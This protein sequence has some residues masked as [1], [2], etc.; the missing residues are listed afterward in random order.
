[1]NDFSNRMNH[2]SGRPGSVEK[3][4]SVTNVGP[5]SRF[6]SWPPT[7]FVSRFMRF[8]FLPRQWKRG[9]DASPGVVR[10]RSIPSHRLTRPNVQG[11]L[12]L[13][14]D[15]IVTVVADGARP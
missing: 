9:Q 6:V 3:P 4:M 10:L 14:I 15:D 11:C 8:C 13:T 12:I 1:M 5:I 7:M 2:F